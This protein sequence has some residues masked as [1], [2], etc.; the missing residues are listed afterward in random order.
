MHPIRIAGL[1]EARDV[2]DDELRIDFPHAGVIKAPARVGAGLRTFHPDVGARDHLEEKLLAFR[3]R[4][5]QRDAEHIA[6]L[7]DEVGGDRFATVFRI[8]A[9]ADGAPSSVAG[10]GPLDLDDLGAHF[11]R[12][13]RCERLRDEGP[14]RY[15]FHALQRSKSLGHQSLFRH[16]IRLMLKLNEGESCRD[17]C[18]RGQPKR[19]RRSFAMALAALGARVMMGTYFGR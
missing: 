18:R 5:I 15:D 2:R 10:P 7:L 12:Q 4:K 9:D 17:C 3:L 14:G 19:R 13:F 8:E 6:P 16:S 1:P 11:G